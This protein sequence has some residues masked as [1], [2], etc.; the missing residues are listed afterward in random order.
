M[1]G[2][3]LDA[4]EI[5]RSRARWQTITGPPGSGKSVLAT[6]IA[7]FLSE[8]DAAVCKFIY[9]KLDGVLAIAGVLCSIITMLRK[10]LGRGAAVDSVDANRA[11]VM[12]IVGDMRCLLVLD[13][14][15]T[16]L[17]SAIAQ[18][19]SDL[20]RA[21]QNL[22]VLAT[23]VSALRPPEPCALEREEP[24]ELLRMPPVDIIKV[25]LGFIDRT[26]LVDE[27]DGGSFPDHPVIV[28]CN[29]L[30]GL[31]EHFARVWRRT[32]HGLNNRLN[33]VLWR[34]IRAGG[35]DA[36]VL[37]EAMQSGRSRTCVLCVVAALPGEVVGARMARMARLLD[38]RV[39]C[40][41]CCAQLR[42]S[43]PIVSFAPPYSVRRSRPSRNLQT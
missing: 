21:C 35:R 39:S 22:S 42:S 24:L 4:S 19:V 23:S 25:F 34:S 17:S 8:R 3:R 11:T 40:C 2:R 5:V 12:M 43:G 20:L 9:V 26:V 14:C 29:G 31:A 16:A 15:P 18:L 27:L 38:F 28:A 1:V 37:N 13:N 36:E 30:P 10:C 33:N 32:S 41:S 7:H 6:E